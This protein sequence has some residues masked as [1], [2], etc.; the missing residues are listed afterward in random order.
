LEVEETLR[1]GRRGPPAMLGQGR[2]EASGQEGAGAAGREGQEAA[3]E[4]LLERGS[5][6]VRA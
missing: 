2:R 1:G 6:G 3:L 4:H 5:L